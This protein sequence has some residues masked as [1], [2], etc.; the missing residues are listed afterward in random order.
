ME[1]DNGWSKGIFCIDQKIR[2]ISYGLPRDTDY[3][4]KMKQREQICNV[5]FLLS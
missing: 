5:C 1:G 3:L 4:R 2:P